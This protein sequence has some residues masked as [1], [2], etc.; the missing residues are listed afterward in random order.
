VR[1]VVAGPPKTG[2]VWLKCMLATVYGLRPL[3][4][5]EIPKPPHLPRVTAWLRAGGFPENAI[6]HQHFDYSPELVDQFA[7]LP[8]HLVTIVRD[9]YDA[10]VSAYYALQT[11]T[12]D[13]KRSGRRTDVILGKSLDSPEVYEFLRSNGF[14]RNLTLS[15]DW[16]QSGRSRVVRYE[17]LLSDP[18][19][20][21]RRLTAGIDPVP[22]DRLAA[23]VEECSADTMRQRGGSTAQHVRTAKVGDSHDKLTAE[24][25]AIFRDQ[26]ADLIPQ[27]GYEV[28]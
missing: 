18:L 3:G 12:V 17:Q 5:R 19:S 28:R 4:P 21:L 15:R 22:D 25:L 20:E 8:A 24:H 9:P 14:R 2:N 26:Y 11:H 23:A 27:L 7:A 6:L 10:F 16:I 1:I 13:G